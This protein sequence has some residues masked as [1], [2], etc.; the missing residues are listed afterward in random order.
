MKYIVVALADYRM[1]GDI[2]IALSEAV[3]PTCLPVEDWEKW[4]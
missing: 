4:F 2:Y 1:G 3:T